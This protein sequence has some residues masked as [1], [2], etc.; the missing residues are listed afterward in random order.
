MTSSWM[1]QCFKSLVSWY[2][3]IFPDTISKHSILFISFFHRCFLICLKI[4]SRILSSEVTVFSCFREMDDLIKHLR[5]NVQPD[6]Q[7]VLSILKRLRCERFW[8]HDR[9]IN[10]R[11]QTVWTTCCMTPYSPCS[12]VYN[13]SGSVSVNISSYELLHE[14]LRSAE[15]WVSYC[16]DF[17]LSVSIFGYEFN[18][19]YIWI[20]CYSSVL[21][22]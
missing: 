11:C 3:L 21:S 4:T 1:V 8:S 9:S 16:V 22:L 13:A 14:F 2:F 5:F 17:V 7:C 10:R 12:T 6:Q 15:N 18:I 20:T 19:T